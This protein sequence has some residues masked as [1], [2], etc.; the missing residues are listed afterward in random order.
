M[1]LEYFNKKWNHLDKVNATFWLKK[2]LGKK[3]FNILWSKLL[4]YKFYKFKD[5]ICS[6][7]G[8]E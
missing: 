2:W 3:A 5:D 1:H 4:E 7:V 8:A 6:L